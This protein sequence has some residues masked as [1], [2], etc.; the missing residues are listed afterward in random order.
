MLRKDIVSRG[1]PNQSSKTTQMSEVLNLG[2]KNCLFALRHRPPKCVFVL[3]SFVLFVV[4][5]FPI[6]EFCSN[7]IL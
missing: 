1:K 7:S 4:M 3:F 2:L 6:L 5:K